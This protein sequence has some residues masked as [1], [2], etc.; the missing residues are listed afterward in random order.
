MDLTHNQLTRM[1][2]T[3]AELERMLSEPESELAERK[4]S[5]K[6]EAPTSVREA[7]CAFANDLP[8]H[9]HAGVVFV[10]VTDDGTPVSLARDHWSEPTSGS[11]LRL[12]LRFLPVLQTTSCG[13]S[14][15]T[16]VR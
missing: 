8:D 1:A 2:Y 4:E 10:G 13:R 14:P 5:F 11:P 7:V 16:A 15:K 3:D 12:R 6:G 9:R